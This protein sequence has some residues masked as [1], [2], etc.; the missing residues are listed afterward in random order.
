MNFLNVNLVIFPSLP[1][2]KIEHNEIVS[3]EDPKD[4]TDTNALY[5]VH[6]SGEISLDKQIYNKKKGR[7]NAPNHCINK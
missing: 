3:H 1:N 4:E 6:H 5:Q 2:I 7:I